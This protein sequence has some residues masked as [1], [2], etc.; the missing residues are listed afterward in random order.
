MQGDS[1]R[2]AAALKR[3]PFIVCVLLLAGATVMAGPVARKLKLVLRKDAVPLRK[4]LT[5]LNRDALGEYKFTH[6]TLLDPATV[7]TL[8]TDLYLDWEF[9]DTAVT[10]RN[11]PLRLVRVLIT[12]Y[13][14][15]PTLVP[16][17]PEVCVT[18]TG[19][20]MAQ[21][22]DVTLDVVGPG[23]EPM[24]IPAR[25]V[26]FQKSAVYDHDR[27][28]VVYTFNCNGDFLPRRNLVRARLANPFE[29]GAYLCKVEV[30][31]RARRMKTR[32]A[33]REET[34]QAAQKFL[35]RILPVLLEEHLPDWEAYC[36]AQGVAS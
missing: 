32:S 35:S 28:T 3:P 2:W 22:G 27:P 31:F 21:A 9:E 29:K 20:Q 5:E 34:I 23:G 1:R 19:S 11:S 14:G 36:R 16:H 30:G 25:A 15:K 33:G 12:Y 6:A 4:P 13:T 17:I 7:A 8:G 24:Q 26:T 18:A 10:D